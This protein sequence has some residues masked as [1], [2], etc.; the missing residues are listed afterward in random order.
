MR[1]VFLSRKGLCFGSTFIFLFIE[2]M[3]EEFIARVE[4]FDR[5]AKWVTS[6]GSGYIRDLIPSTGCASCIT[7]RLSATSSDPI[8]CN[9]RSRAPLPI[10]SSKEQK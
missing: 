3:T 9:G 6:N 4:R 2:R 1:S 5:S 8:T 7:G 10:D